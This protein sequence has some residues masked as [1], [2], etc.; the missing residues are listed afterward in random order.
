MGFLSGAL[1]R[2]LL[3]RLIVGLRPVWPLG[4]ESRLFGPIGLSPLCV[5]ELSD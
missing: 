5:F 1:P 4:R 3:E 2:L